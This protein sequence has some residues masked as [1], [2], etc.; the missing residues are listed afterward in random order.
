MGEAGVPV[1]EGRVPFRDVS[2]PDYPRVPR[3]LRYGL[4]VRL[5]AFILF[6]LGVQIIWTSASELLG[7]VTLQRAGAT[8]PVQASTR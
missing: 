4:L 3:L 1:G 5:T 2:T 6:C 7:T 8:S